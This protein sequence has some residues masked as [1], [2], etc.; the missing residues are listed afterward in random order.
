MSRS[1]ISLSAYSTDIENLGSGCTFF[2]CRCDYNTLQFKTIST[3]GQGLTV[4]ESNNTL[5]FSGASGVNYVR[6]EVNTT[7]YIPQKNDNIIGVLSTTGSTVQINLPQ[8]SSVGNVYW[9]F[10]DEGYNAGSNAITISASTGNFIDN[11]LNSVSI[12]TN[13]GSVTLYNNNNNNW[14]TL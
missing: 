2:V 3:V 7:S 4:T 1:S 13:G 12:S 8:I 10:K 9:L 11:S 6:T 5:L 14:Y